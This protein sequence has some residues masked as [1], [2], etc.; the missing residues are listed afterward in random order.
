M[1]SPMGHTINELFDDT[2]HTLED[3]HRICTTLLL[4]APLHQT[5]KLQND[6]QYWSSLLNKLPHHP[7]VNT[8][9]LSEP[10]AQCSS[11]LTGC[12]A[13]KE[14]NA[15]FGVA[16]EYDTHAR[17]V[18]NEFHAARCSN[19]CQKQGTSLYTLSMNGDEGVQF[20]SSECRDDYIK[21]LQVC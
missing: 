8:Q 7:Y 4:Y 11:R 15:Y 10:L 1:T 9:M 17:S 13:F 20:C 2:K 6:V 18:I 21:M 14:F 5:A 12:D 3:R 16:K 19:L